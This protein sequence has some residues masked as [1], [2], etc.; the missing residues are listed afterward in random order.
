MDVGRSSREPLRPVAS[1]YEFHTD[2]IVFHHIEVDQ[3][4]TVDCIY[5]HGA[6][7]LRERGKLAIT[8]VETHVDQFLR[9]IGELAII[10]FRKIYPND[11]FGRAI[12]NRLI[13]SVTNTGLASGVEIRPVFS[14]NLSGQ[15]DQNR[16]RPKEPL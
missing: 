2:T 13:E 7:A 14:L 3:P 12:D 16:S 9:Q 1:A 15:I 10:S 5:H 4:I 6:S 8:R 11:F